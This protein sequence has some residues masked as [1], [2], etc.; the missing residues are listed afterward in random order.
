MKQV[1]IQYIIFP[2]VLSVDLHWFYDLHSLLGERLEYVCSGLHSC[3]GK[4]HTYTIRIDIA[5]ISISMIPSMINYL[6]MPL[7]LSYF[8]V[9]QHIVSFWEESFFDL[10]KIT[11]H[12]KILELSENFID[13]FNYK[14]NV[15]MNIQS[16]IC[17]NILINAC[18]IY[19]LLVI[20][21]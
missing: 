14:I 16:C 9:T 4:N 21:I 19:I 11:W 2:L 12:L 17:T 3:C 18:L 7:T 20:S 1:Q 8:L 5:C 10:V 13:V 6:S 15:E